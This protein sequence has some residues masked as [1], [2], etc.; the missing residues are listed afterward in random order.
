M[1][2]TAHHRR[3]ARIIWECGG[4]LDEAAQREGLRPETLRRWLADGDFRA[5][6]AQDALE[7]LL[8]ATS[9]ML[10]WA[11]VAV[12]RLIQDLEGE[13]AGDA[14]QAAREILKLALDTQRELARP[15]EPRPAAADAP[16]G[17]D[18]PLSRR[19]AELTDEQLARVLAILNGE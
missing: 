1:K 5:L 2:L 17:P 11:P 8:Q 19:V 4:R 14:R 9:A 16:T 15:A 6:V 18:D 12:A 10:R 3:I 7:P 13:N